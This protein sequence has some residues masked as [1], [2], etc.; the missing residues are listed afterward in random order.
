[1][2]ANSQFPRQLASPEDFDPFEAAI[3]QACTAQSG[4]IHS[5]TVLEFIQRFQIH[6]DVSD[7]MPRVIES[8]FGDAADERHLAAFKA[9][10][11]GTAR[12][13]GLAFATA[14]A[15]FAM[16]AGFALAEPLAAMLGSGSG[17]KVV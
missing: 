12:A 2:R 1:M 15:R 9:D 17:F 16:A 5:G 7:G 10:T 14:S 3:G 6:R 13:S 4:C 8:T 11:D